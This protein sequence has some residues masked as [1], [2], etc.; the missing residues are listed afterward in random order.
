ME[1]VNQHNKTITIEE[2]G[3]SF[4]IQPNG[5]R[6]VP[7]SLGERLIKNPF[8]KRVRDPIKNRIPVMRKP[9]VQTGIIKE[10]KVED[11]TKE[12]ESK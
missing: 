2:D 7:D 10:L 9:N 5:T 12:I 11:K 4:S 8:I 6:I 1:I 3:F